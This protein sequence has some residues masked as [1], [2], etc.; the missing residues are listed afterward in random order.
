M[1]EIPL[2]DFF[3]YDRMKESPGLYQI[4]Y[5]HGPAESSVASLLCHN[6]AQLLTNEPTKQVIIISEEFFIAKSLEFLTERKISTENLCFLNLNYKQFVTMYNEPEFKNKFSGVVVLN[7]SFFYDPTDLNEDLMKMASKV[8]LRRQF[9]QQTRSF[10]KIFATVV[11]P[12][13]NPYRQGEYNLD[14]SSMMESCGIIQVKRNNN[15]TTISC[16]KNRHGFSGMEFTYKIS[17]KGQ[18]TPHSDPE[19]NFFQYQ[20]EDAYIILKHKNLLTECSNVDDYFKKHKVPK[21]IKKRILDYSIMPLRTTAPAPFKLV[22]IKYDLVNLYEVLRK[23]FKSEFNPD[24]F[25]NKTETKKYLIDVELLKKEGVEEFL[26]LLTQGRVYEWFSGYDTLFLD[27]LKIFKTLKL[28]NI[29]VEFETE[30]KSPKELHDALV[31]LSAANDTTAL[32][33]ILVQEKINNWNGKT[34][35]LTI[36]EIDCDAQIQVPRVNK[37]FLVVGTKMGLC[38]KTKWFWDHLE[39]KNNNIFFLKIEND[40]KY[41]IEINSNKQIVQ[42]KAQFNQEIEPFVLD[43]I[44]EYLENLSK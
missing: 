3:S 8:Y 9:H 21:S 6:I 15:Q 25:I 16:I 17:K 33:P 23:T 22:E 1:I 35:R 12:N 18:W 11:R 4:A 19:P 13:M 5:A 2:L 30:P 26:K 36:G 20:D 32:S 39:N 24:V 28:N 44:N 34:W 14:S 42:A 27:S 29:L 38:I 10:L 40:H 37:D 31:E 7:E 43:Q 41:C